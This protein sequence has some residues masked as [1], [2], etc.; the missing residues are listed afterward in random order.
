VGGRNLIERI[1]K[2]IR[3]NDEEVSEALADC[4]ASIVTSVRVALERTPPEFPE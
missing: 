1:P 4:I 3:L 2:T